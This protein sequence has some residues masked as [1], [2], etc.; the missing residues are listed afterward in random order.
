MNLLHL[1]KKIHYTLNIGGA[2]ATYVIP[3]WYTIDSLPITIA[4]P[5]KG[6]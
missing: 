2:T 3:S 4:P 6:I 5:E 1:K